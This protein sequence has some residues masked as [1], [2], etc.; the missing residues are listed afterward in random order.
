MKNKLSAALA[1]ALIAGALDSPLAADV[2]NI[3]DRG[4]GSGFSTVCKSAVAVAAPADTSEDTLATCSLGA[5]TIGANGWVRVT[6]Y[7][8]YT[9]NANNKTLVVRYSGAAGTAYISRAY[10]TT[11]ATQ[12][13]TY[14][15]NRNATNSQ[16]GW[17]QII[18]GNGTTAAV[19]GVPTT[20]AVDT[21][22]A[23]SVVIRCQKAVG[24]DVCQLEGYV[25]EVY[26][27]T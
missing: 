18:D 10:T 8:T 24:T 12:T 9:N 23:S 20:S 14:I 19:I 7:W 2:P 6:V 25:V 11:V 17:T 5:N 26:F 27:S 1:L 13:V 15:A 22:A 16:M 3:L 21:T 4:S